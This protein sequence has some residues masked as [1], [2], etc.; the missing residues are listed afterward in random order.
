M[1]KCIKRLLICCLICLLGAVI[2]PSVVTAAPRYEYDY[3]E[4][5]DAL[6][7]IE[8]EDVR[9]S[10]INIDNNNIPELVGI[11]GNGRL[12]IY[13]LKNGIGQEITEE[14][15][16]K[17]L[18]EMYMGYAKSIHY[19]PRKNIFLVHQTDVTGQNVYEAVYKITK[20]LKFKFVK[21]YDTFKYEKVSKEIWPEK[22]Y[23]QMVSYLS[24]KTNSSVYS[25][26]YGDMKKLEKKKNKLTFAIF[27]EDGYPITK[28]FIAKEKKN[29][30]TFTIDKKCKWYKNDK[31][32]SYKEFYKAYKKEEYDDSRYNF[33]VRNNK[34]V[35]A[36]IN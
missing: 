19:V 11:K 24:K 23:K 36:Y 32:V 1:K 16:D 15:G 22:D 28:N 8:G 35:M 34:L 9:Y 18:E 12:F 20:D 7:Y 17:Y 14:D 4:L 31:Q 6:K 30:L 25:A 33:V 13:T 29:K 5:L 26:F 21:S 2:A 27:E 3:M 10:L